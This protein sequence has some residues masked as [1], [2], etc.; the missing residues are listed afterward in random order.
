MQICI[1]ILT[2][3]PSQIVHSY[4]NNLD[5][6]KVVL[7]NINTHNLKLPNHRFNLSKNPKYL[8]LINIQEIQAK[9]EFINTLILLIT[10]N[11]PNNIQLNNLPFIQFQLQF[12]KILPDTKKQ[13]N[14]KIKKQ[15]DSITFKN[16]K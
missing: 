9:T 2:D 6:L 13:N 4:K 8:T 7:E 12:N 5:H 11:E 15:R 14:K 10:L 1:K 16:K 3:N